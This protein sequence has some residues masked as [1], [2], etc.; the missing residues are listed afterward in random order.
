MYKINLSICALL[1]ASLL[2]A[3][4]GPLS[5][6]YAENC[7]QK[8]HDSCD[9]KDGSHTTNKN[10]CNDSKDIKNSDNGNSNVKVQNSDQNCS[11]GPLDAN[12]PLLGEGPSS[13]PT[14]APTLPM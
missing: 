1:T 14:S 9:S 7:P 8:N 10:E 13:F 2:M 6:V 11:D 3:L 5:T 4:I 12:R